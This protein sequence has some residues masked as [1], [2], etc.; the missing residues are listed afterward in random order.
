MV[1]IRDAPRPG[2]GPAATLPNFLPAGATRRRRSIAAGIGWDPEPRSARLR[3]SSK[4][5]SAAARGAVLALLAALSLGATPASAT[6][7]SI[8]NG[9]YPYW[10]LDYA[11]YDTTYAAIDAKAHRLASFRWD[12]SVYCRYRTGW[13]GPGA[14]RLGDRFKRRF[15]WD[16]GYPWQGPGVAQDHDDDEPMAFHRANYRREFGREPVCGPVRRHRHR[17]IVLRRKD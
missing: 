14:Y 12:D 7:P 8:G 4:P 15:G 3:R 1:S 16:G 11:R 5:V 17:G 6:S 9:D 10:K 13:R 2:R